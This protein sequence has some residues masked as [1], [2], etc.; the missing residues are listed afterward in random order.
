VLTPFFLAETRE[1]T[2]DEALERIR[3]RCLEA[4]PRPRPDWDGQRPPVG[5][6]V[7]GATRE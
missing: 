4:A 3:D 5:E 7:A 6:P 2:R 1:L